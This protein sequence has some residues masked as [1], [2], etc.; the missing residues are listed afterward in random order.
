[1]RPLGSGGA[2]RFRRTGGTSSL[3]IWSG[4]S[5]SGAALRFL[6]TAAGRRALHAALLVG[7]LFVLGLL[8]GGRAQAADEGE[9][10]GTSTDAVGRVLDVSVRPRSPLD[11]GPPVQDAGA[12]SG[13]GSGALLADLRPVTEDVVRTVKDQVVLT[14]R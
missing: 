2:A 1:M 6:R 4:R 5:C 7:G 3:L 12:V 8:C 9:G 14:G 10:P 13:P 11:A